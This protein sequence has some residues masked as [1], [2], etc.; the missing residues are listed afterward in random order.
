MSLIDRMDAPGQKKLL[1]LDGGGIRGMIT[2]EFLAEIENTLRHRLNA[3]PDFV[4]A[5]YFDYVAG[6][7]TGAIIAACVSLGMRVDRIVEFYESN[8]EAMFEKASLL[9]RFR[10]KYEDDRLAKKLKEV[11]REQAKSPDRDPDLGTEALR[12][13]L[14][15]VMRNSSTDSPWPVSNN[16]RAKYNRTDR[17]DCNLRIPLWQL[18]RASTAAPVYFPPE[19]V[20]VGDKRFIFVDG[21]LTMYNN[22]AFI[23]FLMSTLEPYNLNWKAGE[24]RMLVVSVGTG[25]NPG[26][27]ENLD[28]GD[29]NLLYNAGSVPSA[30]MYAALNEQDMLCRAF[31][32]CRVGHQLDRE[33]LTLMDGAG[34]LAA[35][36]APGEKEKRLFTY[37]RYNCEL[38]REALDELGLPHIQPRNVQRLD[39]VQYI[40]QLR[41]VGRTAASK[42]VDAAHFDGF[43]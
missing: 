8:G 36:A 35:L 22:P 31:G 3:G 15:M 23:L 34:P 5:D 32:H 27:N 9:R 20:D 6:T 39:S 43:V 17:K 14:M 12:T 25:S 41:E 10:Y 16:P 7:S 40:P 11:V 24:D 4:L 13:L 19:V 2:L 37:M 30:L 38:S 18:I 26:A 29:M 33:I 42:V 1:A 21:G 28:P